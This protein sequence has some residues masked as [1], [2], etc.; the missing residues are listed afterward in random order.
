MAIA[1]FYATSIVDVP[2][3]GIEVDII[4]N[5]A[6]LTQYTVQWKTKL[7]RLP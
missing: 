7:N 3:P 1:G 5:I 6:G 2:I 4:L